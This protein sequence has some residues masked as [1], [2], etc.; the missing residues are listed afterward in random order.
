MPVECVSTIAAVRGDGDLLA[1]RSD[2]QRDVDLR[3]RADLQDDAVL[4]VGVEALQRDL[5][6]I[7]TDRQVGKMKAPSPPVTTVRA[8]PVSI[9]VMVTSAPGNAPPLDRGPR[10]ILSTRDRLCPRRYWPWTQSAGSRRET[11]TESF[12]LTTGLL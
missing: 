10:P 12:R 9:L 7:R 11:L 3:V 1:D 5:Q 8:A 4:H 2:R 6:L